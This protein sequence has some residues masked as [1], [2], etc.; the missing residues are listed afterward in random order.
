ME[1]QLQQI[2]VENLQWKPGDQESS[3]LNDINL[4]LK[5]GEFYGILGPNGAGK[6]SFARQLL[7][8]RHATGGNIYL[9]DLSISDYKR[10]ELARQIA[11]LPQNLN[12]DADFTVY[13]IVAMGRESH[14]KPFSSLS[15]E[16]HKRIEEAMQYTNCEKMADKSI[17]CLSGGERQRV[18]IARTIVQDTPWIILDEPVSNLDVR[19]QVEL[20]RVL[21]QLR[22]EK[23][24]TIVAI[25]HDLNLAS[26]FC[27][28]IVLMQ[29]GTVRFEGKRE[30]VLTKENLKQVY[31]MEFDLLEQPNGFPYIVPKYR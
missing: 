22:L 25:L 24:K 30:E 14:K 1:K 26:V 18:M 4:H 2:S 13:E 9:D 17:L 12:T 16:D 20:M 5:A 23:K 19:H 3:I 27:T 7:R 21:E 6:T 10:K 28:R 29:E 8:L 11:F 31:G 15:S